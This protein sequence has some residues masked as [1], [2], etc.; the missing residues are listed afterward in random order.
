M[1]DL[2]GLKHPFFRRRWRRVSVIIFTGL[3]GAVELYFGNSLWALFAL[4]ISS[5]CA[6][7][8]LLDNQQR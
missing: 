4:G 1:R 7:F 3:W 5:Y 6:T 2:L 8:W